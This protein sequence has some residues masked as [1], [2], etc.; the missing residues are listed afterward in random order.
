M[1]ATLSGFWDG[2]GAGP[3]PQTSGAFHYGLFGKAVIGHELISCIP[4]F[5][6]WA[7]LRV[8][9]GITI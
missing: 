6:Y 3:L 1:Q 7:R 5:H 4:L 2:P 9:G 8:S